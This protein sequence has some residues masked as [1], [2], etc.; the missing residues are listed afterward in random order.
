MSFI[1]PTFDEIR[2]DILRDINNLL[3]NADTGDDSDYYIRASSVAS[4]AAGIYQHQAWIVRQIFPDTADTDYLEWHSRVRSIYRKS[5]TSAT[6]PIA[7]SGEA[8]STA[9]AGYVITRGELSYITTADVTI[10]ADG[11]GTVQASA[12][13]SG[14]AGN[15]L[16]AASG[17]FSSTPT[18]FDSSVT[19]G[20]MSG[21][22]DNE[23]DT[24]LL[25]RLLDVIRRP[26]AGGNQFDYK[27][28]ALSVDGVSA[29][30]VYPLRRG[31]GTVDIVVTSANGMSS[32]EII[33][34]TQAYIDSVRP[35]TAKNTLVLSPT[36]HVID[37]AVKVSL[38]GIDLPTATLA[39]TVAI[40]DYINRLAPGEAFIRSQAETVIS[41]ITGIVDRE[42][43]SPSANVFPLVDENVV[44]WIRLGEISVAQI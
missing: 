10:G 6:G 21:G 29:A 4:V 33:A 24:D 9:L 7:V 30:Y 23:S 13:T 16:A 8:G 20:I 17:I 43:V 3:P 38:N 44:E 36:F 39:I 22:T 37:I 34:A 40:T 12:S 41:Q 35:V 15:T 27:R 19:I 18:G 11:T 32:N 25:S 5:Q 42:I 14:S 26:P 28:W 1:T 2:Q 31:L